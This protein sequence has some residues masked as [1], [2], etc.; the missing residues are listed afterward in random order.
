MSLMS[1]TRDERRMELHPKSTSAPA[2][3]GFRPPSPRRGTSFLKDMMLGPD[4]D[5]SL[6]LP[7]LTELTAALASLAAGSRRKALL[8]VADAPAE[9]A[10]LRRGDELMVSYY[11]TGSAPEVFLLDRSVNLETLLE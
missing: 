4:A 11:G 7:P 6:A 1:Y 10:L 3:A 8:P 9:L 2:P 5:S